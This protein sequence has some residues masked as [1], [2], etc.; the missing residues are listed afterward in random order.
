MGTNGRH[1]SFVAN[2]GDLV[3]IPRGIFH[4]FANADSEEELQVLIVFNSSQSVEEDDI[5]I[6]PSFNQMP[7]DILAASFG[8]PEEYFKAIQRNNTQTPII[9]RKD[10]MRS[11]NAH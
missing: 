5:G 8:M 2:A 7:A 9:L 3:F 6:V 11:K 4:Y 1:E 10:A